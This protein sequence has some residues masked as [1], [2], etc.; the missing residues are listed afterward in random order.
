MK[1]PLWILVAMFTVVSCADSDAQLSDQ[2]TYHSVYEL[3]SMSMLK[4]VVGCVVAV[5]VSLII[6]EQVSLRQKSGNLPGP[7][8][9]IP[10][11][12]SLRE[13]VCQPY[14]FWMKQEAWGAK[15][16]ASWN[17][18]AGNFMLLLVKAKLA[19][20]PFIQN[21]AEEFLTIVD[22][23]AEAVFGKGSLLFMSGPEHKA[24]K[25]SF[26]KL[27]TQRAVS[28]YLSTQEE[29]FRQYAEKWRHTTEE[30]DLR[31]DLRELNALTSQAA[32][33]GPY[34]EDTKHFQK[35]MKI[36]G[37]AFG[38]LPINI[39]GSG[40]WKTY[41]AGAEVE[42][43]LTN[44][45]KLSKMNMQTGKEPKCL[46]DFWSQV[47]LSDIS[48]AKLLGESPPDYT[49]DFKMATTIKTFLFAAQDAS[50]SSLAQTVA[51]MSDYPDILGKVREEQHRINPNRGPMTHELLMK[52]TYTRQVVK[53]ILRFQPPVPLLAHV[54]KGDM[55]IGSGCTAPKG[56]VVF[57]CISATC[58]ED[59]ANPD[60]FD[61]DRMSPERQEDIKHCKNYLVFGA[62]PHRCPGREYA[63]N[64]LAV[65]LSVLS[66]SC[67]W[68]RRKTPK[69]DETEYMPSAYPADLFITFDGTE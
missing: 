35:L 9:C 46:L 25:G 6:Y 1:P 10:F 31:H 63:M 52:M 66:T 32:F 3:L 37:D 19:R 56:T 18:V 68:T 21:S 40:L 39:P 5:L 59:F 29:K 2:S 17:Y 34:I 42:K 69:S 20:I 50:T 45:A 47:I 14:R 65:F 53:E 8:L 67:T 57:S 41:R 60:K 38:S 64:H 54:S 23:N 24:L 30:V 49:D 13:I 48:R 51:L 16:G 12:G 7:W 11:I 61:P 22:P 26:I 55:E 62:G 15:A 33:V 43:I 36:M 28:V 44:A 58:R 27:L 4:K